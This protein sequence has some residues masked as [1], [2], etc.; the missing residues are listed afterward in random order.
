MK[1][2]VTSVV[3]ALVIAGGA[4][5]SLAADSDHGLGV[6]VGATGGTNGLGI[7]VAYRF[8][9]HFGVRANTGDYSYDKSVDSGDFNIDGKAKLK[10]IGAVVDFY[11]LGGSFRI[12][13]GMRS[14]RNRFGGVASPMGA[15]VDVGGDTYTAS[16]VGVLTGDA[17]FKRSAAT[18]TI[19]WGG[20]FKT[21]IHFGVDLGVVAQG[22]PKLSASSSGTLASDP[23]FQASLDEQLATWQDDVKDYKLWPV[24][25]LHLA[26]R[27]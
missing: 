15:T 3:L 16:Q 9:E 19:G 6:S 13:L 23:I 5:A 25:Q 27:F 11:P 7:E 21:G 24:I 10:S 26:Y 22:S 2:V 8:T 17:K 4:S 14:D 20:T 18:A 1:R 12:S